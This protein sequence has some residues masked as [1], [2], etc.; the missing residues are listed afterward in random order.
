MLEIVITKQ[1]KSSLDIEAIKSR[2]VKLDKKMQKQ[3]D[4][5]NEDL[6]TAHD[7]K[8]ATEKVEIERKELKNALLSNE[9]T[10]VIKDQERLINKAKSSIDKIM[11]GDRIAIKQAIREL[12]FSIE[13]TSGSNVGISWCGD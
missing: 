9:E 7:L 10:A 12:V 3:I 2:L 13:I 4:A 6:I 1:T 11:L 5:Y 8:I